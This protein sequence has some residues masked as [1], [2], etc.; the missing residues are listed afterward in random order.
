LGI[1]FDLIIGDSNPPGRGSIYLGGRF[2][3]FFAHVDPFGVGMYTWRTLE[4]PLEAIGDIIK[5]NL[6]GFQP[7]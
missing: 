3:I 4:G 5:P 7:H 2:F 1:N 6:R